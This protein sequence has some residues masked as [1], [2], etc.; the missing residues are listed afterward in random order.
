[1]AANDEMKEELQSIISSLQTYL[2]DTQHKADRHKQ[3]CNTLLGERD[4][5]M[6][7]MK[8]LEQENQ[9]LELQD[10]EISRLNQVLETLI[11]YAL[12][13]D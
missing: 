4:E 1:M 11:G 9:K 7:H 5:L 6:Q 3:E 10:G 13:S 12:G 8:Q 2:S